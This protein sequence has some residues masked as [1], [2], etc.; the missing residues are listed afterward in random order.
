MIDLNITNITEIT[1]GKL[2]SDAPDRPVKGFSID[3]RTIGSGEVFIAVKGENFDGHDFLEEALRKGASAV[4]AEK[5]PEKEFCTKTGSVVIVRD[6]RQAMADIAAEIRRRVDVRVICI[7]GTSGKTTVKDILAHLL[8]PRYKVLKSKKSYN[9]VIGLSLT[10]FDLDPSYDVA[11]LEIGTNRPGEISYL[12]GIARPDIAVIT[13]I[14]EGHLEFLGD[15]EHIFR[16]KT[17]FLRDLSADAKVFLNGDDEFLARGVAGCAEKMFYGFSLGN[18]FL[19]TDVLMKEN[20]HDF[21]VG[22]DAFFMPMEGRHNVYNAAAAIA[23]AKYIGIDTEGIRTALETVP[24]P[25]MRLER[26]VIDDIVFMDDSYNAN[27]DSFECALETLKDA[28]AAG[29]RGV[30]A[31]D[32]MELGQRSEELHR[33]IGRS[34]AGKG[35]DFLIVVGDK[36]DFI[37]DDAIRSGM[38]AESVL[39]ARDHEHAAEILRETVTSGSIVL[40]KGSRAAKMEEVIRCFTNSYTR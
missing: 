39:R 10:L 34:I 25:D 31:G 23:V 27:P 22:G 32:M 19:I 21:L 38:S 16:E 28:R 12:A 37:A 2:L 13:N 5:L 6:A 15:K 7:T 20:G 14:G 11:V 33:K 9:S 35:M 3:S 1:D 18:D 26:K 29:K 30:V 36:A 17:G 24:F 40:V 4:I 8:A